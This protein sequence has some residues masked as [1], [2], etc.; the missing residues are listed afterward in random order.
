MLCGAGR[1]GLGGL[2]RPNGQTAKRPS[3]QCLAVA[4]PVRGKKGVFG[5]GG[6]GMRTPLRA[7]G[8]LGAVQSGR[9]GKLP[10]ADARA[11]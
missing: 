6:C 1:E 8:L 3:W 2:V 4:W 10:V 7:G 5:L 11:S 9:L